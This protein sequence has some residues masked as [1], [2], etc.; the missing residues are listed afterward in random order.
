MQGRP[1][2]AEAAARR[3]P[4]AGAELREIDAV[5]Q[6]PHPLRRDAK[7]EEP[8]AEPARHGDEPLR[9]RR[10]PPD[11]APRHPM[12]GDQVEIAAARGHH[13]RP[14]EGASQQHR[15]DPVGIEIMGVDQVEIAAQG[16]LP[17]QPRQ[18]CGEEGQGRRAHADLGDEQIARMLDVEPV[19]GLR[20]RHPGHRRIGPE[21]LRGKREP[22]TGGDDSRLDPAAFDQLAQAR[23]DKDAVL[24]AHSIRVERRE[25]QDPHLV[26]PDQERQ[27]G[28][29]RVMPGC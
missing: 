15:G 26:P 10:G 28:R 25:G 20:A 2:K 11:P 13:H 7:R 22:R 14:A 5:A 24:R 17:A 8:V 19:P 16:D 6:H 18:A 23:L 29:R 21:P 1:G 3:G 4:V 12:L 9:V 27:R